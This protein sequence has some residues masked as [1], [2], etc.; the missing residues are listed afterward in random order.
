MAALC[1]TRNPG[2][3]RIDP[4]ETAMR[5]IMFSIA[6]V[7]VSMATVLGAAVYA[8][9]ETPDSNAPRPQVVIANSSIPR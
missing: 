1:S 5:P 3:Q 7:A 6:I 9:S 2:V 8:A 4:I